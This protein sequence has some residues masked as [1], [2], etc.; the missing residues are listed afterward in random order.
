MR[1]N[2]AVTFNTFQEAPE[3]Y[4]LMVGTVKM[5]GHVPKYVEG[6]P[7]SAKAQ[8]AGKFIGRNGLSA[9]QEIP[10]TINTLCAASWCGGFPNKMDRDVSMYVQQTPKGDVINIDACPGGFGQIATDERVELLQKCL[11]KG[12]CSDNDIQRFELK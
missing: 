8:I 1:P 4:R 7:L 2:T 6:K 12:K 11:R 5:T 9:S 10:V 3:S